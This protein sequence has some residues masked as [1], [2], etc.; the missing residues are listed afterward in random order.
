M[1]SLFRSEQVAKALVTAATLALALTACG[2]GGQSSGQAANQGGLS[3]PTAAP[4]AGVVQGGDQNG[5]PYG[6][7]KVTIKVAPHLE[8]V[9]L[10]GM[11]YTPQD[12]CQG[13]FVPPV[14]YCDP[15]SGYEFIHFTLTFNNPTSTPEVFNGVGFTQALFPMVYPA[16]PGTDHGLVPASASFGGPISPYGPGSIT[17]QERESYWEADRAGLGYNSIGLPAP[18]ASYFTFESFIGTQE[19]QSAPA[20]LAAGQSI[21]LEYATGA[22]APTAPLGQLSVWVGI[23]PQQVQGF[24]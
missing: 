19:G 1:T 7:Y 5:N 20:T 18:F 11:P 6:D 23:H 16:A 4:H 2:T 12:V 17:Q 9:D 14:G 13:N 22:V 10:E 15:P 3:S 8:A 21:D 24:R